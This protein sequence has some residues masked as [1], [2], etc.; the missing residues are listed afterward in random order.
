MDLSGRPTTTI[1]TTT[2]SQATRATE[3]TE[4]TQT[5]HRRRSRQEAFNQTEHMSTTP[6]KLMF[7]PGQYVVTICR[8]Q[9]KNKVRIQKYRPP[10]SKEPQLWLAYKGCLPLAISLSLTQDD[11]HLTTQSHKVIQLSGDDARER[12][13]AIVEECQRYSCLKYMILCTSNPKHQSWSL[14]DVLKKENRHRF[15]AA[16]VHSDK[17]K[18]G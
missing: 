15:L 13:L 4:T 18:H 1:T 17:S 14:S 9:G 3:T 5:T 6:N 2:F 7:P 8:T 10:V 11:T 12:G 16:Y